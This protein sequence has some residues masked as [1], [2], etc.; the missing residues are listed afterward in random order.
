MPETG[1]LADDFESLRL[2][3]LFRFGQSLVGQG[4]LFLQFHKPTRLRLSGELF[5]VRLSFPFPFFPKYRA[6]IFFLE[7][8][9]VIT[10]PVDLKV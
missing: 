1:F 3:S 7:R 10:R 8:R 4:D 2:L 5:H 9:G 6:T